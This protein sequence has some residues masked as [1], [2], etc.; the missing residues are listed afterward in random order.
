MKRDSIHTKSFRHIHVKCVWLHTKLY[1]YFCETFW[2]ISQLWD[3]AHAGFVHY[4]RP[5][6]QGLFKDFPGPYLE[7]SRTFFN[8]NFTSKPRKMFLLTS[9]FSW[10]SHC[11]ED[12]L[13]ILRAYC[14]SYDS[15]RLTFPL[16][17][18][19]WSYCKQNKTLCLNF[20]HLFEAMTYMYRLFFPAIFHWNDTFLALWHSTKP[21]IKL[22][23]YQ[24][25]S[26]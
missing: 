14:L 8:D 17:L 18:D 21:K 24:K 1:N 2:R 15:P 4:F 12:F 6:I 10:S 23:K 11:V 19:Q 7:I 22:C 25:T 9:M 16:H 3:K 26:A 13:R 5:K 20:W